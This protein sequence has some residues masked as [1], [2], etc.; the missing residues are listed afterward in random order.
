M[1]QRMS[2]VIAAV[3]LLVGTAPASAAPILGTPGPIVPT[4]EAI[5]SDV[6]MYRA[7]FNVSEAT[8]RLEIDEGQR[9]GELQ[10]ELEGKYPEFA[11]LWIEHSPY[12][13]VVA[14]ARQRSERV[15]AA[16][17]AAH[18]S[19]VELRVMPR[20]LTELLTLL[21]AVRAS[22]VPT[23]V[24]V[25]LRENRVDAR[26]ASRATMLASL[27]A[28]A[29]ADEALSVVEVAQ[30]ARPAVSLWGGLGGASNNWSGCPSGFTVRKTGTTTDGFFTAGHCGNVLSY[31]G[32]NLPFQGDWFSGNSDSQWHTAP[33]FTV[34]DTFQYSNAGYQRYVESERFWDQIVAGEQVCK[35]GPA[36]GYGCGTVETRY[37]APSY[38]PNATATYVRVKNCDYDLAIPGDSGGPV[39]S[40]TRAYGLVSGY[41]DDIFCGLRNMLIF[42]SQDFAYYH[43]PVRIK[44]HQY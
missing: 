33:G 19:H 20:S 34:T 1:R 16:V 24:S 17:D 15:A 44:V 39:F 10:V 23:D 6:D 12:Q 13:V 42:S 9:V 7:M 30:L 36:G 2:A 3:V 29:R 37:L 35:Y 11:G 14:T 5:R 40:Y 31:Q 8:A 21:D 38:I 26:T 27:A 32:V 28:T 4:A 18:L 25:N 43:F 41:E 22:K